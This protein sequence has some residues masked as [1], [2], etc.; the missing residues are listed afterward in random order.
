MFLNVKII[1]NNSLKSCFTNQISTYDSHSK[2]WGKFT[3]IFKE[4]NIRNKFKKLY[5]IKNYKNV[6]YNLSRN[7]KLWLDNLIEE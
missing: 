7:K 3:K 5:G 2:R 1:Q 6:S 4:W